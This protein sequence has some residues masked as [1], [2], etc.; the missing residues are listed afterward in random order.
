MKFHAETV[1]LLSHV[2]SSSSKPDLE[3]ESAYMDPTCSRLLVSATKMQKNEEHAKLGPRFL[4]HDKE[5]GG[6]TIVSV[7]IFLS[8]FLVDLRGIL[9]LQM[10]ETG[11]LVAAS[12][13]LNAMT[14]PEAVEPEKDGQD[15]NAHSEACGD[16]A[17]LG[18][19]SR[20][21][22]DL[23]GA[24]NNSQRCTYGNSCSNI[25]TQKCNSTPQLDLTLRRSHPSSPENHVA[26]ERHTLNHSNGS[27]FS[28]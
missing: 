22:I 3:A 27:A 7:C 6:K 19:S 15:A 11:M 28:R 14:Q 17:V 18:S 9:Y 4:M 25:G 20:E 13:D 1:C 16:N 2:Q 8:F 26:D 12:R 23:I 21:A 24:F 10:D 5:A